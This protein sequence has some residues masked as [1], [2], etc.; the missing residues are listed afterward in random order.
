[1]FDSLRQ[2]LP[3]LGRL[4]RLCAVGICLL[5]A[6]QSEVSRGRGRTSSSA[7]ASGPVVVA[8]RS[9]PAGRVLRRSDLRTVRW[10]LRLRPASARGS[11]GVLLG[12]RLTGAMSAGEPVTANRVLGR[13]TLRA[14]PPGTVATPVPLVDA[15]AAEFVRPGDS[16]DVLAT[17]R[18]DDAAITQGTAPVRTEAT[19]ALVL[20]VFRGDDGS[21]A[22]SGTGSGAELVIATSRTAAGTF[23]R[24]TATDVF[25]VVVLPP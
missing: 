6:L 1:V 17:A 11:P 24:D 16:V 2:R 5:L 8:A 18:V 14:G 15:H 10:P 22:A 12:R 25:T 7:E 19:A 9:L 23:A 13:A 20:A 4:P 21:G 3:R